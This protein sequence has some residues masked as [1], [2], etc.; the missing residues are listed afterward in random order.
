MP[1]AGRFGD[2]EGGGGVN[3]GGG[4]VMMAVVMVVR[5]SVGGV[6]LRIAEEKVGN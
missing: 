6:E 5:E 1:L 4:G 2:G 3:E